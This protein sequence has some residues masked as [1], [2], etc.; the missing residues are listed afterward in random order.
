MTELENR[1]HIL[2]HS[3]HEIG[4]SCAHTIFSIDGEKSRSVFYYLFL[5][6]R[7]FSNIVDWNCMHFKCIELSFPIFIN[8]LS[9]FTTENERPNDYSQTHTRDLS[10]R[11]WTS[12]S[13]VIFLVC[14][15]EW[16]KPF[17]IS[18]NWNCTIVYSIFVWLQWNVYCMPV[19]LL[20][21]GVLF[22]LVL[23]YVSGYFVSGSMMS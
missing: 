13:V 17:Q 15:F 6:S 8:Y 18:Q 9:N 11:C 3:K 21:K 5:F 14:I 4:S 1:T 7:W 20:L 19:V 22:V 23:L 12:N 2:S 16:N 10:K